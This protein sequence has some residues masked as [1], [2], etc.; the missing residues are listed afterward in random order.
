MKKITFLVI[1]LVFSL[2]VSAQGEPKFRN[3]VFNC[4]EEFDDG[5]S[6]EYVADYLKAKFNAV[7]EEPE[8][9]F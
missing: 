7:E 5:C 1:T 2:L 9:Q 3:L 4:F 6:R 8:Y